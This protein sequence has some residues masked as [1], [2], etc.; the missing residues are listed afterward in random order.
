L[1]DKSI[2]DTSAPPRNE[3]DHWLL[4]NFITPYNID[5]KYKWED[6]ESNITFDL[7]PA[8]YKE[9][10]I[11]S[12]II[13]HVWLES[14]DEV[15]GIDF[16]R[17]FVPKQLL[18]VGSGAFYSDTQSEVLGTAEGGLKVIL[19]RVN[20][21]S[22][23]ADNTEMLNKIYFHTMHHE[24][25]HILH[26]TKNYNPDFEKITE[27]GYIGSEWAEKTD[28][29]A[30]KKGFITAYAMDQPD[31]D[32]VEI[33]A[34]RITHDQ[35][36]WDQTMKKAGDEGASLINKKFELVK[37]YLYNDWN[38]DIDHLRSVVLRRCQ[39]VKDLNLETL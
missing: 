12:K 13:K 32:F 14:Y 39:E 31:E 25:A 19:Y 28:E 6:I 11:L 35:A 38:I 17:S 10:I 7:A 3:F 30:L 34:C 22:E 18:F 37:N 2:F 29:E 20:T 33:I 23:Y 4:E 24:F 16:T 9:S 26:A 5:V 27:S 8:G 1:D 36:W 21:I 15:C